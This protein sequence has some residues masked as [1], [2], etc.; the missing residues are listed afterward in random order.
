MGCLA[1]FFLVFF[2]AGAAAL[3]FM[4]LRPA[5]GLLA[6]RSWVETPCVVQA[7]RVGESSDSDGTTYRVEVE[8]TYSLQGR[9]YRSSRYNFLDFYSSGYD[10]KAEVVARYPPGTRTVCY[11]DPDDPSQAVIDR[12]LSWAWLVG[13]V[14][15]LFIAVGG[16]GLIAVIWSAFKGSGATRR[17]KTGAA[18]AALQSTLP[19]GRAAAGPVTLSAKATPFG[20]FVAIVFIALFWNGIVSVFL[21][22]VV[23]GWQTGNGDGCLTAFLVPFLLVGLALIFGIFRQFLVL[24]NP[25][26]TVIVE[27]DRLA[28]G[29]SVLLQWRFKGRTGRVTRFRIL[30]EGWEEASY[31]QGTDT[32]TERKLFH[33]AVLA[34]V[35]QPAAIPNGTANLSIPAGTVPSFEADHNKIL[36]SLKVQTE[37]PGWP[38]SEEELAI[39][40][41]PPAAGGFR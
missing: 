17:Q 29:E 22:K 18:A 26:P 35:T 10:G 27:R 11:V 30:L 40:V 28:P 14:P 8:Y 4:V 34:D 31:R 37:I 13:L 24:F 32:R 21:W 33:A 3:Y 19:P 20:T 41:E 36:W 38:D 12:K 6:S 2:L 7:S 25:R 15:L 9:E 5:R 39:R 16:G 23:E 1:L